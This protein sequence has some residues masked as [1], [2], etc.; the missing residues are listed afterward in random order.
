MMNM[1]PIYG[2]FNEKKKYTY[3]QCMDLNTRLDSSEGI[4]RYISYRINNTEEHI[5]KD[6]NLNRIACI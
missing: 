1:P 5:H 6:S 2:T 4:G 3:T